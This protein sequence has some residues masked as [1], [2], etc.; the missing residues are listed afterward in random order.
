MNFF[1]LRSAF[2][3]E[4]VEDDGSKR[5]SASGNKML[6]LFKKKLKFFFPEPKLDLFCSKRL[7]PAFSF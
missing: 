3:G 5:K 4:P 2:A 7:S 1:L 6:V